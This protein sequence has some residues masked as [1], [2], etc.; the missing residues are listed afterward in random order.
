MCRRM[1]LMRLTMIMVAMPPKHQLF[2]HEKY[3]NAKKHCCSHPLRLPVL[4]RMRQNLK[5][6]G[7]QQ[8]PNSVRNQ[9]ANPLR[10]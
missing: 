5:E 3:Q 1:R 9:Q 4:Q 7:P 8:R 6:S 2:E 10:P